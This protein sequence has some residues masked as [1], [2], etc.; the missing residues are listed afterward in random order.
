[1]ESGDDG[2]DYGDDG[3]E[4]DYAYEYGDGD[5]EEEEL[6]EL[7]EEQGE[8]KADC[9]YLKAMIQKAQQNTTGTVDPD[10]QDAYKGCQQYLEEITADI[11]ELSADIQG[12]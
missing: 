8:V 6:E 1:M 12:V 7:I 5:D 11:Q 10:L 3:E 4:Y 2:E 9:A